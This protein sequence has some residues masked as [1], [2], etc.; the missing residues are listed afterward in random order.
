MNELVRCPRCDCRLPP[1]SPAGLCPSCLVK[2]GFESQQVPPRESDPTLRSPVQSGF[3]PPSIDEL[4]TR[5]PQLEILELL[6]QGGMGAVYKARQRELGRLVAL[7]ILPP[8][9]GDDDSFAERFTREAR[10]LARLAHSHIVLIY[11]FGRAGGLF[12]IL[13]E[14]VDGANLRQTMATGRLTSNEALAIIPQICEA[15]QFAHDEGIVHRDIKP[16]NILI[17]KRGRVKIA[18]FGLAKL[19][20]ADAGDH[21]LTATHQVMGTL[22]YMAPEQ[23]QGSRKVDHRADIY[24]LGV[25]FYELLT[26]ELPMGRFAPPS[27]RVQIDV[28][29]DEIVLKALEQQPE[30]RYQHASDIKIDVDQFRNRPATI[31]KDSAPAAESPVITHH[32]S[33]EQWSR[34]EIASTAAAVFAMVL[35]VGNGFF[36]LAHNRSP[37]ANVAVFITSLASIL[38]AAI[39]VVHQVR[40]PA[41]LREAIPGFCITLAGACAG[42][43]PWTQ[44]YSPIA[45]WNFWQGAVYASLNFLISLF[46][47][48]IGTSLPRTRAILTMLTGLT[49]FA[50]VMDFHVGPVRTIINDFGLITVKPVLPGMFVAAAIS[51]LAMIAGALQLRNAL[52]RAVFAGKRPAPECEVESRLNRPGSAEAAPPRP[53]NPSSGLGRISLTAAISGLVLPIVFLLGGVL[54]SRHMHVPE[55]FVAV[56]ILLGVGME[57]M[58]IGCGITARHHAPGKSGLIV[59]SISLALWIAILAAIPTTVETA[60]RQAPPMAQIADSSFITRQVT[61]Y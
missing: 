3:E 41:G 38:A 11:D 25:V 13:M 29:L 9:I 14:Y 8:E 26:G 17:D 31:E 48:I 52:T 47:L 58:A 6:G 7:K 60:G 5:F 23:T 53:E 24:S 56:C 30:Q 22:R 36:E 34:M 15:L 50:L 20:G 12:Y 46:F 35:A 57:L 61:V 55:S 33:A 10:A 32:A 4:A 18:D 54:L 43:L 59:G 1:D 16:E 39:V 45:G 19:V 40:R 21:P 51:L 49:G 27:K 2:A 28:R 42:S 37:L 44:L